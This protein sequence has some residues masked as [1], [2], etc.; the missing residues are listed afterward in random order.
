VPFFVEFMIDSK[1][2][3]TPVEK[4]VGNFGGGTETP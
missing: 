4:G 1:S 3:P 2:A